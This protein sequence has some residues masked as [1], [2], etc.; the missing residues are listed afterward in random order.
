MAETNIRKQSNPSATTAT[1]L[2][3]VPASTRTIVSSIRVCNRS[4]TPTTFRIA[5]RP[6]GAALS[7]EQYINYDEEILGN[8]AYADVTGITLVATDIVTV[9]ATAATLSFSLFGVEVT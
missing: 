2:Y 4:A 5:I 7:N 8:K 6:L 3:T 9:Y 1:T